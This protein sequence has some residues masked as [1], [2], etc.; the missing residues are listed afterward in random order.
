MT[1]ELEKRRQKQFNKICKKVGKAILD[2]RLI[3]DGDR[4]LVGLS[5]GKD[6]MILLEALA[7]RKKHMALSVLFPRNSLC[8]TAEST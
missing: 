3:D 8:S 4:V 2:F 6:S 7:N 1:N 5:G